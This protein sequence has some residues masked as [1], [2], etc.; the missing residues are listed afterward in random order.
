MGAPGFWDDQER[1]G[2]GLAPSTRAPARR[3]ETLRRRSQR[4]VGD[5]EALLELAD[6][7]AVAR[8]RARRAARATIEARLAELE[9]A[10][11]VLG[12]LRRRRRARH[13]QRR[14][15]RHRRPGLGRD[16]AAHV[17]ALGRAARLRRSSCSRRAP[18]EE[19]GI[20]SATFRAEGENAY[21]LF[22]AER[23]VHRLVRLSPFDSANRR[24]TAFAG[25]EVAPVVDEVGDDR[26]RRRRPADRHL[27]RVAAPAASTSTRPTRRCGSRTGRPGSSCSARTSARRPRTRPTAMQMLRSKLLELRGAQARARRSPRRRAR[28]RTSNFGSQIRS[29]VLHPYTMVK[30]HRTELRDGRRPARA[31]RRPRRLRPRRAAPAGRRRATRARP[32]DG[33]RAAHQRAAD[34]AVPRRGRRLRLPRR[35]ALPRPRP[36]GR[37]GRRPRPAPRDRRGRAAA[38]RAA[39]HPRDRRRARRR[40]RTSARS[41]SRPRPTARGAR[42][43][44]PTARPRATT[45]SAWRSRRSARTV[46]AQRN[47][48]ASV[49]DGLVLSGGDPDLR[50]ARVRPGARA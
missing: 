3:L 42:G 16:G 41:C 46:V 28:R 2:E 44:S 5:L 24:Q 48:H 33:R 25:V 38:R 21:G 1:G 22:G 18:G 13:R 12:P 6:E 27:P 34:R 17:P 20:K 43:S 29:Y 19:A 40:R 15:R 4:D 36:Q 11:P 30:D 23:G 8:G 47:S 45:R 7:D 9:E 49:V 35:R 26:D 37:P 50:R 14:R 31:R 39:G 32:R 10:A